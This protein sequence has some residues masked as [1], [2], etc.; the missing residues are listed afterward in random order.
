MLTGT[1]I[2]MLGLKKLVNDRNPYVRKTVAGGL[3]KVYE[4]VR[5]ISHS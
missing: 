5:N 3:A 1:G 4:Y 2:V